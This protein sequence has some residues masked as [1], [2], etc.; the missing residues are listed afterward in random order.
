MSRPSAVAT[1]WTRRGFQSVPP[2][3]TADMKR[4][5]WIGVTV[6][7][8]WPMDMLTVSPA[9]HLSF[10]VSRFQAGDGTSP[11]RSPVRP[12]SVTRPR[13]NASAI[14]TIFSGPSFRPSW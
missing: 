2:F 7:R 3:A 5:T 8:P 4:A 12:L 11:G 14:C 6:I 13:P 10:K 1:R 9:C